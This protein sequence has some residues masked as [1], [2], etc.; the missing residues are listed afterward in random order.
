M[1]KVIVKKDDLFYQCMPITDNKFKCGKCLF[2][3]IFGAE[4][5]MEIPN[6]CRRCGAKHYST[7]WGHN[8]MDMQVFYSA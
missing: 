6:V 7:T 2:G 1:K 8:D 3:V 4:R 5:P